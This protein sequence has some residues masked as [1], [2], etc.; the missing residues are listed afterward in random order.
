[1]PYNKTEWKDH[2]V[3]QTTGEIIQQGTPV[4]ASNLNK[5]EQGIADAHAQL[6]GT[7]QREQNL[8]HGLLVLDGDL[9][10]PVDIQIEGRTLVSLGNSF[11]EAGKN[12][13]LADNRTKIKWAD[14]TVNSGIGKFVGKN[15]RPVLIRTANFEG[16]LSGSTVE[17]PHVSKYAGH[18]ALQA[19][20]G[21]FTEMV[22]SSYGYMQSLDG[23]IRANGYSTNGQISQHLFSFNIIEE[24]E[25]NLGKIPRATLA[26]KI[27]W[28]KDNI[29]VLRPTWCGFGTSVNGNN[30]NFTFWY[31]NTKAWNT[32]W[33]S[34]TNSVVTK[35]SGTIN[36]YTVGNMIDENGMIHLLAYAPASDG[37]TSS[38]INTEYVELEI[39]LKPEAVIHEPLVPLYEVTTAEYNK[40]LVEWYEA[41][42]LSRYPRVQGMRHLQNPAV[43]ADGENLLPPFSEWT[44]HLNAKIIGPYEVELNATGA[45]QKT[46]YEFYP[47]NGQTYSFSANDSEYGYDLEEYNGGTWIRGIAGGAKNRTFTWNSTN[48]LR[49]S[50]YY[51]PSSGRYNFKNPMLTLGSQPK[52][53]VPRNPSYLFADGKLGQIGTVKDVLFK[54]D[55]AW[56][57]RNTVEKD[58]VLDGTFGWTYNDAY[59]GYK[60]VKINNHFSNASALG[61]SRFGT[62]YSGGF[63]KGDISTTSGYDTISIDGYGTIYLSVADFDSGWVQAFTPTA[64]DI[65]RYFNGWKYT[66]GT[67]WTSVTGNGQTATSQ[68]ALDTKPTDYTPYKLSYVLSTP[69]VLDV[70]DKVEGDIV[71]NGL[72]Q[73]E[74]TSGVI[75][76]EKVSIG[77]GASNFYINHSQLTNSIMQN[78][79]SKIINIYKGNVI[80]N[81]FINDGTDGNGI[82]L[83]HQKDTFDNTSDY[84]VTYL[85]LDRQKLTVN[86]TEVKARYDSSLKS[87]VDSLVGRGADQ[88]TQLS[89]NVRAIAELYKRVRALGG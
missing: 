76:R 24:I 46:I 41:E 32:N 62:K 49:I 79:V 58:V 2:V 45:N 84:Y 82:R 5:V 69:Q 37:T 1:M 11:L 4:S 83:R 34:T 25:R 44:T 71:V 55:G 48:K 12:Y 15:E 38:V 74:V 39:E 67:T 88:A 61:G 81:G 89:V 36:G 70:S 35:L 29:N 64:D 59:P 7:N 60:R 56:K 78:K 63:I 6:E 40:I 26:N 10:S 53:F 19:P 52:S 31:S 33:L 8:N 77:E 22:S 65:K 13:V 66:D 85:V 80:Y 42:V 16:K 3:D 68:Q 27:Q 9:H 75:V 73:M 51:N 87:V 50:T 54:Q 17:N 23:I 43:I 14:G 21:A 47:I 18:T 28:V 20:G 86:A 72:T 30:G 57:L